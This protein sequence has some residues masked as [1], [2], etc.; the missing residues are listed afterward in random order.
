MPWDWQPTKNHES[1]Q[2][3]LTPEVC[4]HMPLREKKHT[5]STPN[6]PVRQYRTTE[7]ERGKG[8]SSEDQFSGCEKTTY[9]PGNKSMSHLGK[10]KI[11]DSK[12][13]LMGYITC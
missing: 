2:K 8:S 12:G 3:I 1:I 4:S 11:I 7:G 6:L 13:F 5:G 9:P 10:R